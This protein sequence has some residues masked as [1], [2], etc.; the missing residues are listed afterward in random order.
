MSRA[1]TSPI[2]N[3]AKLAE[4][5][6]QAADY[7]KKAQKVY[8]DEV[9]SLVDSFNLMLERIKQRDETIKKSHQNLEE[10]VHERTLEL[11]ETNATLLIERELAQAASRAKSDFLSVMS[12]EIRTP[13]NAIVG[14]AS[15]MAEENESDT[16]RETIE[17]I[18]NSSD[19]LLGLVDN[20][21][22]YSKIEAGHTELENVT[23]PLHDCIVNP[24]TLVAAQNEDSGIGFVADCAPDL[25]HSLIG[26]PTRLRQIVTNLLSNAVKFTEKGHV[27]LEVHC[28]RAAQ[29][30]ILEINVSDTGIGIPADRVD[31][32]FKHFSQVDA[33]MTRRYGGTGLGLAIS[34]RLA[35][36]MG[37]GITVTSQEGVGRYF[38]DTTPPAGSP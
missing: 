13:M 15:L 30:P 34:Q 19:A 28:D 4:D 33:S 12:H 16:H 24:L 29:P 20:I 9:G 8:N 10:Q 27:T 17:I 22:D 23:F 5:V 37:G 21:L 6:S 35:N 36:A 25:P 11:E 3:L 7:T 32:L 1:I 18:Q 31:R 2:S 38:H 14:M 26:D